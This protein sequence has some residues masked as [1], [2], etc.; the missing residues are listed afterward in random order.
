LSTDKE[1]LLSHAFEKSMFFECPSLI[2][3]TI[4]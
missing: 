4:S 2:D 3:P 1:R